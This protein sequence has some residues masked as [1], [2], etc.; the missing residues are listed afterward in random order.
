MKNIKKVVIFGAGDLGQCFYQKYKHCFEILFFVDNQIYAPN[1]TVPVLHPSALQT[2][3]FDTIY[4]ASAHGLESIYK[5]LLEEFHILPE[6]INKVWA[7]SHVDEYFIAP[8]IR[9]LENYAEYCY[10]QG[11]DGACAEVGV[12]RGD[13]ALEINR[14]FSD[15]KLYLY[16][17][18]EGFD[19]R[20]L[21]VEQ[22]FNDNYS[23]IDRW[24]SDGSMAFT[25]TSV[26][27]VKK[28]LPFPE[29]VEIHKGFFPDTFDCTKEDKYIFVNLDTDLYQPIKDGLELFYPRMVT[30]GIILV[31]D[32]YSM[33]FGVTKAVDEF[34]KK[35][36]VAAFPIGDC[37]SIAI[38]KTGA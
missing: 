17:T 14:V 19:L 36:K 26:E 1:D 31:H 35:Y 10:L 3:E 6:K 25:D 27:I 28:R 21:K 33:L 5:Q 8:R 24:V 15:K 30:G 12:C 18:F 13:F 23:A 16:D 7:E 20:D 2:A 29:L 9:F 22:E 4:I 11:I 34:V 38:I 32:Y 37:K